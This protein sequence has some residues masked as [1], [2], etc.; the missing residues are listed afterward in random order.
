MRTLHLETMYVLPKIARIAKPSHVARQY[1]VAKE[2][3]QINI[4]ARQTQ[5]T[6]VNNIETELYNR[7][8][9]N[10]RKLQILYDHRNFSWH[11][12]RNVFFTSGIGL[13]K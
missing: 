10:V 1:V 13:D 7:I 8:L 2:Q 12:I 4:R 11:L 9:I 6:I 5:K 3:N